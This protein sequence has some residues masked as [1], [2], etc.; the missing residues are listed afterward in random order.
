MHLHDQ[1]DSP[2][3]ASNTSTQQRPR[4]REAT[5]S[6][7]KKMKQMHLTKRDAGEFLSLGINIEVPMMDQR[8][9]VITKAKQTEEKKD[10]DIEDPELGM[11][12]PSLQVV[13]PLP[14]SDDSDTETAATSDSDSDASIC[15]EEHHRQRRRCACIYPGRGRR[16]NRVDRPPRPASRQQSSAKRVSFSTVTV[17]EH[18]L[19]LGD[20]PCADAYP[21]SLDWEHSEAY[22]VDLDEYE[23]QPKHHQPPHHLSSLQ[24]RVRIAVVSG[25]APKELTQ[26]EHER[27]LQVEKE[28]FAG[29]DWDD[30]VFFEPPDFGST[31]ISKSPSM[32]RF[33][34]PLSESDDDE[35]FV[36]AHE[37]SQLF[38][39]ADFDAWP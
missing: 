8:Y 15:P 12:E 10:D 39:V 38:S 11:E 6:P 33:E 4:L 34:V 21:L 35:D 14:R 29:C 24:R 31:V 2:R 17:Q 27:H 5:S 1:E 7:S 16:R 3:I 23:R 32:D 37:R 22:E 19:T 13:F 36:P 9:E 25:I 30:D 20:H 18:S 28:A 26:Q